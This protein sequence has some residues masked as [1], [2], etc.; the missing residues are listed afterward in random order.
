MFVKGCQNKFRFKTFNWR[1]EGGN[2]E[3]LG[4]HSSLHIGHF[5]ENISASKSGV[6]I[7]EPFL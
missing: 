5:I 2:T 6:T 1:G 4:N 3:K 7:K